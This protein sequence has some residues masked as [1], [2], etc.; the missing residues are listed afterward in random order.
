M[1][2]ALSLEVLS[3]KFSSRNLVG[4]ISQSRD[5]SIRYYYCP[6]VRLRVPHEFPSMKLMLPAST[7][8]HRDALRVGLREIV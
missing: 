2:A 6:L 5:G 4:S 7:S 8:V 3:S 1:N